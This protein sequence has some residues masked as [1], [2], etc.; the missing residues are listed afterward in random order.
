[1]H[2]TVKHAFTLA[3]GAAALAGVTQAHAFT[4]FQ[5]QGQQSDELIIKGRLAYQVDH[6]S[7]FG[8]DR[9]HGDGGSRTAI[10]YTHHFDDKLSV[11]GSTEWNYDPFFRNGPDTRKANGT[12]NKLSYQKR[13]QFAGVSYK[14]W[15]TLS[16]GKQESVLSMVTDATD[17]YWIFGA[18]ANTKTSHHEGSKR[19]DRSIKYVNTFGDVTLGLMYGG[20]DTL[21]K[22]TGV[23]TRNH[24]EQ[25]AATWQVAPDVLLGAG[26]NTTSMKDAQGD[27]GVENWITSAQWTPGNWTFS[28]LASQAHGRDR[29]VRGYETYTKY[30][31]KDV[32]TLGT[33]QLYGGLNRLEDRDSP[34][35]NSS[36]I[37]GTALVG[38]KGVFGSSDNYIVAVEQAIS[39]NK[40]LDGQNKIGKDHNRTSLLLRYNY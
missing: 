29:H 2:T 38:K 40:G 9:E 18:D 30:D 7:G 25:I 23:V 6:N 14:G 8:P 35:R 11:F 21:Y 33:V 24:F 37:L 4:A 20:N 22:S 26:Y 13:H 34:A 3:L 39:D 16:A 15:G 31:F 36:Y 12:D 5:S 28:A 1:M 10:R 17:Q 19:P 27:Y 32:T